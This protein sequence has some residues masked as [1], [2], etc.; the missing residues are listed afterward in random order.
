MKKLAFGGVAMIALLGAGVANAATVSFRVQNSTTAI[1]S[2]TYQNTCGVVSPA[3][4][5]ATAGSTS[6]TYSVN[7]G[8]TSAIIFDYTSGSKV[9]RFSLS[10][11]YTPANPLT[12]AA[13][14]W[15]PTG[16]GTSRGGSARCT[17]TLT[18]LD[19]AGNYTWTVRIQ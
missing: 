3:L 9:C 6:G 15:T 8:D 13:A 4:A 11:I 19:N 10:S 16:T 7:C 2:S 5:P 12:G 14:Y 17:A 18:G 1:A